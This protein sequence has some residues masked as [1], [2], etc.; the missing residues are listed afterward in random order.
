MPRRGDPDYVV[1][2]DRGSGPAGVKLAAVLDPAS[3]AGRAAIRLG[4][5]ELDE[6][7]EALPSLTRQQRDR[8]RISPRATTA[9]LRHPRMQRP[10]PTPGHERIPFSSRQKKARSKTRVTVQGGLPD[11]QYE[12]QR[13]LMTDPTRWRSVN[14]ALSADAG[15]LQALDENEQAK[16]RQV[17][18]SIQAYER[19]NDR[20]HVV[21]ANV[22]MPRQINHAN[23][24]SFVA[25]NFQPG[26]RVAFDRYTA[27]THQLHEST[28]Y[29]GAD[30]AGRVAVFEIST[31]RGAY[32]GHSDSQDNTA[33][34]LPR[35]ME[36][37]IVGSHEAT[38]R[39]P[40]GVTGNRIVIQL[41]DVTP[42]PADTA[43]R[44]T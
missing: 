1:D 12:A 3:S 17:D 23:L 4:L 41:R 29:A 22:A 39:G 28:R 42:E 20:G 6:M 2:A 36:L 18:R 7:T 32:L 33:H 37:E 5:R 16:I 40:D 34:L 44:S 15:D 21:Y 11:T 13:S 35:G 25:H 38:W 8:E 43:R 14:D 27:G 26:E 30:T 10:L 31:R 19:H 24:Q 9:D